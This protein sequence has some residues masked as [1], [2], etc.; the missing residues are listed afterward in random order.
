MSVPRRTRI[1][2]VDA[3][4]KRREY[5]RNNG[6]LWFAEAARSQ[7][8]L[9]DPVRRR[10]PRI[11]RLMSRRQR[12]ALAQTRNPIRAI[13]GTESRWNVTPEAPEKTEFTRNVGPNDFGQYSA[14]GSKATNSVTGAYR[15]DRSQQRRNSTG[16]SKHRTAAD[17][18][19]LA[20]QY[21][22]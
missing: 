12:V 6:L 9:P 2:P 20:D 15:H 17:W 1:D 19:A 7:K 5:L 8:E 16:G 11:A 14:A 18:S 10:Q 21:E 22:I 4:R 13:Y 3:E